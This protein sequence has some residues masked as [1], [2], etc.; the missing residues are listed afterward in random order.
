MLRS[1]WQ[2]EQATDQVA[3]YLDGLDID[4][5]IIGGQQAGD[6]AVDIRWLTDMSQRRLTSE[7]LF[8]FVLQAAIEGRR[9]SP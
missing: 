4:S 2:A 9:P 7:A 1:P 5:A 3:T 8:A 6:E